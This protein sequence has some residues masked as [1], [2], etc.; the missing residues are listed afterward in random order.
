MVT[1]RTLRESSISNA[2]FASMIRAMTF[3]DAKRF[4][5]SSKTS[6]NSSRWSVMISG[7]SPSRSSFTDSSSADRKR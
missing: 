7:I 1:I 4:I 6:I 2:I 5:R 3:S